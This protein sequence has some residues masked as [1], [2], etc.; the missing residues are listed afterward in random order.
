LRSAN[1]EL[2]VGHEEA[3]ATAEEVKTLNEELQSTNEELVT[4]NEELE[5]TVEELHA[6][7]EDLQARTSELAN[8]ASAEAEQH[9]IAEAG[10]ARMEAVLLS[11]A[12]AVLIVDAAG[13]RLFT[14]DVYTHLF[15]GP[16]ADFVVRDLEGNPLPPAASP[17]TRAAQ[18]ERFTI[19]FSIIASDGEQRYFEAQGRPILNEQGDGIGGVIIMREPPPPHHL[20]GN[21]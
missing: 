15:G 10:R 13:T 3:E 7:N 12:D 18:G 14:T 1:E 6:A 17:Q 11:I 2:V 21:G 4:L 20:Q 5:A 16:N 19:E 8:M 9:R